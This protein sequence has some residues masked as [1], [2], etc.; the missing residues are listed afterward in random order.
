MERRRARDARL[1]WSLI[2]YLF[3]ARKKSLNSL[4]LFFVTF[5]KHMFYG[6]KKG[7]RSAAGKASYKVSILGAKKE[8]E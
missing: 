1:V 7:A 4:V 6:T 5:M 8:P 2:K 3:W